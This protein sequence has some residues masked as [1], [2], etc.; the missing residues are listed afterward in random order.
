[1]IDRIGIPLDRLKNGTPVTVDGDL[2]EIEYEN[3]SPKS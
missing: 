3:L 2:G 1:M